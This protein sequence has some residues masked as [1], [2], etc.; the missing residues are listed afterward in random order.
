[1]KT[2]FENTR[3]L[4]ELVR[5]KLNLRLSNHY[6]TSHYLVFIDSP[7]TVRQYSTVVIIRIDNS[8]RISAGKLKIQKRSS[9][10]FFSSIEKFII[11]NIRVNRINGISFDR[12]RGLL[13]M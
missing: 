8:K 3:L 10:D 5:I 4:A 7:L 12:H 6:L 1:M 2:S 11:Y 9:I 13:N